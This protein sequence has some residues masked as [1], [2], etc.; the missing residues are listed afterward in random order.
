MFGN[1]VPK[2]LL[3]AF[4]ELDLDLT[5]FEF[6]GKMEREERRRGEEERGEE[7]RG[8]RGERRER[9]RRDEKI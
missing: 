8:E 4:P 3:R 1:S 7:E 2:A 5:K 6:S 9:V